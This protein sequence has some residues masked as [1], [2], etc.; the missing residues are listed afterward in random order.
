[1]SRIN[2]IREFNRING[3]D[4][5]PGI[6]ENNK[7]LQ[8]DN[9]SGYFVYVSPSA[10]DIN[11]QSDWNEVNSSA[12]SFIRNKPIIP[13]SLD[14]LSGTSDDVVQGSTNLYFT[15]TE[16]TKLTDIQDGAEVNVQSDW[17]QL[18]NTHDSFILNKPTIPTQLSELTGTLDDISEGA[19][20]KH[21]TSTY[22]SDVDLNTSARHTHANKAI[23]DAIT[24]VGSGQIITDAERILWNSF[25]G[26]TEEI[27]RDTV[28]NFIQ[29]S[30]GITWV[31]DDPGNTF[32]G[33]VSLVD[34]TTSNLTEGS[35]LYYTDTRSRAALSI[36]D[37]GGYGQLVY[38]DSTG[39][40]TFTG[41]SVQEV[42]NSI[43]APSGFPIGYD[44]NT[45]IISW[46]AG[47]P[48][49]IPME[50]INA[51]TSG[52]GWV[53]P[54]DENTWRLRNV[55]ALSNKLSIVENNI[56]LTLDLDV[57]TANISHTEL[58]DI[59]SNTHTQ[60]DTF[61]NSKG[62]NNG[63]ATLDS[64]GKVPISQ[65]PNSILTYEGTWDASAN[66]PVLSDGV[67]T[68]GMVYLVS[69]AGT[70]DL[71]SGSITFF[72]GDWIIYNGSIWQRST[73][74]NAVL[75]VNSQ[76]GIVVLDADD[77]SDAATTNKF[78]TQADIARLSNTSGTNTGD[79]TLSGA[80][81]YI[82]L[83]G[84][85]IVR[86]QVD[87]N[88]D[89]S[90]TPSSLPTSS[91]LDDVTTNG[92][93]TANNI[94]IGNITATGSTVNS[95]INTDYNS[96]QGLLVQGSSA[97]TNIVSAFPGFG[98]VNT[99]QTDNN[100]CGILFSDNAGGGNGASGFYSIFENHDDNYG[101]LTFMTRNS[102]GY[103]RR[104]SITSIGDVGINETA[105]NG[106]LD[107]KAATDEHLVV[108][109][110]S[111]SLLLRAETEVGSEK[112]FDI[113]GAT[114]DLITG[115]LNA[116][117]VDNSGNIT[118][119]SGDF[120]VNTD[121][122][123]V[124]NSTG[125]V[126]IGT[127]SPSTK[128]EVN[129]NIIVSN[130]SGGAIV[131]ESPSFSN[132]TLIPNR[133]VL[134]TGIGAAAPNLVSVIADDVE[135]ARFGET[136]IFF[137]LTSQDL[138]TE[139]RAIGGAAL[140]VKG[141]DGNV[142]VG[143]TNP[144]AKLEVNGQ[145]KIT[146][147]TPGVGKVL[148]SDADGLASWQDAPATSPFN[149]ANGLIRPITTTDTL[150]VDN[151]QIGLDE[152]DIETAG[153]Q[154]I[155]TYNSP[156]MSFYSS[157]AGSSFSDTG[158]THY[159]YISEDGST[160]YRCLIGTSNTIIE[161]SADFGSNWSTVRSAV[162]VNSAIN[163]FVVSKD[164]STVMYLSNVDRNIYYS[165]DFG[166]T[167]HSFNPP[168][169][170]AFHGLVTSFSGATLIFT[171]TDASSVRHIYRQQGDPST[172]D[173]EE[174]FNAGST[175]YLSSIRAS[176]VNDAGSVFYVRNISSNTIDSWNGTSFDVISPVNSNWTHVTS[177]GTNLYAAYSTG[178]IQQYSGSGTTWNNL[179]TASRTW[180]YVEALNDKLLM[181]TSSD[182]YKYENDTETQV[183]AIPNVYLSVNHG[184]LISGSSPV[185]TEISKSSA[186]N[187]DDK[188]PTL[189]LVNELITASGGGGGTTGISTVIAGS[190]LTGG[191]SD[192]AVTVN[193][194]TPSTLNAS[195]INNVTSI[196]HTHAVEGFIP[197]HSIGQNLFPISDGAGD[198]FGSGINMVWDN[199]NG[200]L[201][202]GDVEI[203]GSII[204]SSNGTGTAG[205][206]IVSDG[207]GNWQWQTVSGGDGAPTDATYITQTPNASLSAEQALSTLAT[208]FMKSTTG[209][210][211]V[212]TQSQISLISDVSGNL[213]IS[214]LNSGTNA[215]SNTFWRGDGT[216]ATPAAG[217]GGDMLASIYDPQ[218]IAADAFSLNNHTGSIIASQVSDFDTEVS[219]N[220]SVTANTAKISAP[221]G[222]TS[223]QILA[224]ASNTDY[225]Y[226]WQDVGG[227]G[228]VT[229]VG[230]SMPSIFNVSGSPITSSGTLSATLN[231][232]TT[233]TF[234]A[235]PNA[236]SGIPSFRTISATDL[237]NTSVSA[238]SYI[239][240]NITVDAQGR[241]TSASNGSGGGYIDPLTTRGDLLFR[242]SSNIT[243]RLPIGTN[244]YVLTSDGTDVSWQAPQ[245]GS[246]TSWG[247]ITGT[248][249]NQT[250]LQTALDGK[251]AI[252]GSSSENFNT[253]N[254]TV[255]STATITI[256]TWTLSIDGFGN[257]EID[258]TDGTKSIQFRQDVNVAGNIVAT[259]T[260]TGNDCIAT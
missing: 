141:S 135:V 209:T 156:S 252:N 232:Q 207:L 64:G 250:D 84:Q 104:V 132:P 184:K 165:K 22:R 16:R 177:D 50:L 154:Y 125:N 151:F 47:D 42:R 44:A 115:G 196:S 164:G 97:A 77:V 9:T 223:G 63:L 123:F 176:Y 212:S 189:G 138:D 108:K 57:N 157:N 218:N 126:G 170:N 198:F 225:D 17:N 210:G 238:G 191:G 2:Q 28:A 193:L 82:T 122:L 160:Q 56:D 185:I 183:V 13:D 99:D 58:S 243:T 21:F 116:L 167:W 1:M 251:A 80:Y 211:I 236:S 214:N 171:Y 201:Q 186:G 113:N 66:T 78:T 74:S 131:N 45:G 168:N 7:L 79:I 230:L 19:I 33:T 70:Q 89:I 38:D 200:R 169:D 85:D 18:D 55:N 127:A 25:S 110:G 130:T 111:G 87:Y 228:T 226:V 94:S 147:G 229:S 3:I 175:I 37:N 148:T 105:P 166:A 231:S 172:N 128:L 145:V 235:A 204:D 6:D 15:S 4:R 129:G 259:G 149:R 24:S 53:L 227:T 112:D 221:A 14:D 52:F 88:T 5:P 140:F 36:D 49:N 155:Y 59:G 73:N 241:I 152:P 121:D 114:I 224:K 205:Q 31:H 106:K 199:A 254:L 181:A 67:G 206:A 101:A 136:D 248:L 41:T 153:A 30:T 260:I 92:N 27:I 29:N 182:I 258:S 83:S 143:T 215:N 150:N 202:L 8:W 102:D 178:L 23:L 109:S 257:L 255:E 95:F 179:N 159:Y 192:A 98:I 43:S 220:I 242:N 124:D 86:S 174:M 96:N 75:S 213:P 34:F 245:S 253:A 217:G 158:N 72:E 10:G 194:G 247:D 162:W 62:Q 51:G 134:M 93:T 173:F 146:G 100:Y 68:T 35:N 233:K 120:K 249:S 119:P 60:L 71:G 234:F 12:D 240:A 54:P 197:I 219:N 40:F 20:N 187:N 216:W 46:T 39:I 61:V 103:R 208:G 118:I 256:G 26:T 139:I 133:S 91:T 188:I 222:G 142:G 107:V 203:T 246:G 161:K 195:T 244:T 11:V 69:V 239:N 65:L 237:P 144:S 137:N 81:D 48:A 180:T 32:T 190:G 117:S 90:N 76:T 163:D